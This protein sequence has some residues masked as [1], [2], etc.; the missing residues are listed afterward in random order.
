MIEIHHREGELSHGH[1]IG[2]RGGDGCLCD[3]HLVGVEGLPVVGKEEASGGGSLREVG[4]GD[5]ANRLEGLAVVGTVDGPIGGIVSLGQGGGDDAVLVEELSSVG[6]VGVGDDEV[7]LVGMLSLPVIGALEI[8][9]VINSRASGFSSGNHV[10]QGSHLVA[11]LLLESSIEEDRTRIVIGKIDDSNGNDI[12]AGHE[13]TVGTGD[14]SVGRLC[15]TSSRDGG[16]GEVSG[17][18]VLSEVLNSIDV[19][20]IA[21]TGLDSQNEANKVGSGEGHGSSE[22]PHVLAV[23]GRRIG[24]IKGV[25]T[26]D[27]IDSIPIGNQSRRV[28]P[29]GGLGV[30]LVGD[31]ISEV[32]IG[33]LAM[34]DGGNGVVAILA[35]GHLDIQS[36]T[37]FPA[38]IWGIGEVNTDSTNREAI[39]HVL[40]LT[41]EEW[42]G[43]VCG[44]FSIYDGVRLLIGPTLTDFHETNERA[45]RRTA[46]L[47]VKCDLSGLHL[48]GEEVGGTHGVVLGNSNGGNAADQTGC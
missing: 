9:D 6:A 22:E 38:I 3:D 31:I 29:E 4:V 33:I 8:D 11:L 39:E 17:R 10:E 15:F 45:G 48:L 13:D 20:D 47:D 18:K 46:D 40:G 42:R 23:G 37:A 19:D 14:V 41:V 28:A 26:T 16:G 36:S 44:S 2:G 24:G 32:V 7:G 27:G 1:G 12:R 43:V 35:V 34:V 30:D 5:T 25:E 21:G